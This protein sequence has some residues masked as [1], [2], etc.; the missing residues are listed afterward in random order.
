MEFVKSK[1]RGFHGREGSYCVLLGY[2]I[3]QMGWSTTNTAF[4]YSE[5][6]IHRFLQGSE[7]ETMDPGK[8]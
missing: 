5:T 1:I 4:L 3:Y 7:K 2:N 8:Q 6:S